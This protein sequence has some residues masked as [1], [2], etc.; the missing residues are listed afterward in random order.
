MIRKIL[1]TTILLA[2]DKPTFS[3]KLQYLVK[4]LLS[5]T[6]VVAFM[7]YFNVWCTDN[8][9]FITWVIVALATNM[10]VGIKYHLKMGT[11]S[12]K[13]FFAKNIA[14]IVNVLVVYVL[15]DLL[16]VS[17]GDN[18]IAEGFKALIQVTTLLHPVSKALKNIY[19][20]NQKKFPPSFIMERLYNFEKTGNLD[21]LYNGKK[22]D[23][24]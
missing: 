14:M 17:A 9:Q 2:S 13:D 15:L 12:W 1:Y 3:E 22:D 5:L 8:S 18:L 21:D 16:R 6:P 20:L 11:F 23:A 19:I 7:E 10:G 4:L 24:A